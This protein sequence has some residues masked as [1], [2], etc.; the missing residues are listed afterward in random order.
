MAETQ[1]LTVSQ[2]F[3]CLEIWIDFGMFEAVAIDTIGRRDNVVWTSIVDT[4]CR[5]VN[6]F[7][8]VSIGG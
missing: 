6:F 4:A 8:V 5:V 3:L 2:P 7:G 1:L